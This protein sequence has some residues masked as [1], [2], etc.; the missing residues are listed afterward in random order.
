MLVSIAIC[1]CSGDRRKAGRLSH[2][3]AGRAFLD[4]GKPGWGLQSRAFDGRA[5][6]RL[7][8]PVSSASF[9]RFMHASSFEARS[10]VER[11]MKLISRGSY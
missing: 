6:A 1:G 3:A 9:W 5:G 2:H 4:A 8:Q 10:A 11:L 7:L